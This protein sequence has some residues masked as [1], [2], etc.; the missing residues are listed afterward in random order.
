MDLSLIASYIRVPILQL[1][2]LPL[3]EGGSFR[4]GWTWLAFYCD[5][6]PVRSLNRVCILAQRLSVAL[7]IEQRL[8]VRFVVIR[9]A[10]F[11]YVHDLVDS[12]WRLLAVHALFCLD[13]VNARL[14][15]RMVLGPLFSI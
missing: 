14:V 11:C 8:A 15:G 7:S 13:V 10:S 2:K 5:L 3:D 6:T 1:L 4:E 9:G 12:F